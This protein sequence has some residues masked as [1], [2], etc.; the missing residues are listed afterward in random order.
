MLTHLF[1]L[2]PFVGA[3]VHQAR[4]Q[5]QNLS[6]NPEDYSPL[7]SLPVKYEPFATLEHVNLHAGP[8][9]DKDFWFEVLRC[10]R[11]PRAPA[12]LA[13]TNAAREKEGHSLVR[14]LEWANIGLQQ[15]RRIERLRV[16]CFRVTLL[17]SSPSSACNLSPFSKRGSSPT[18]FA[19]RARALLLEPSKSEHATR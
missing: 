7:P 13:R 4:T 11:D 6:Q 3:L 12:V 10:A 18:L 14:S 5:G 19:T 15:V 2:L 16:C 9:L 1:L 17:R 8:T